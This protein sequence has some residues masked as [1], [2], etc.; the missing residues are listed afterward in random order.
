MR[1]VKYEIRHNNLAWVDIAHPDKESNEFL[2]KTFKFHPLDLEDVISPTQRSKIDKY[3]NYVFLILIFPVYNRANKE[4]EP[5][6]VDLFLGKDFLVTMHRGN[7]PPLIDLFQI[8]QANEQARETTMSSSPEM[9]LYNIIRKLHLYCYPMLDHIALDIT[10]IKKRI[11]A[12]NEREM[13]K[14]ILEIRRNITDFRKTMDAHD[15]VIKRLMKKNTDVYQ[16]EN[17]N[18][19]YFE[20]LTEYINEIWDQLESFKEFIEA[21]QQTNESLISFKLN[22]V[23]K[24][25]TLISVIIL[26]ATFVTSLFSVNADHVPIIGQDFDFWII[27]ALTLSASILL[28]AFIWRKKWF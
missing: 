27:L 9:L 11:F 23:M 25:L 13:V 14:N 12:E 21:L 24:T 2:A 3:K 15:A 20:D 18:I 22:N 28:V 6:E 4:I 5:S 19:I 8:C 26:P 1:S 16:I 10:S 7:L 17:K